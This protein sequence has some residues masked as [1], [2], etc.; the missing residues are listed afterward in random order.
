MY[1]YVVMYGYQMLCAGMKCTAPTV[2]LQRVRTMCWFIKK[3][4]KIRSRL[5]AYLQ[6]MYQSAEHG[7]PGFLNAPPLRTHTHTHTRISGTV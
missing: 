7:D 4:D 3:Y 5:G 6:Q 1:T 2:S